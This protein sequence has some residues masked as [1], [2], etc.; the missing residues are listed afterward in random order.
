[1]GCIF[2]VEHEFVAFFVFELYDFEIYLVRVITRRMRTRTIPF[3]SLSAREFGKKTEN[4]KFQF[5]GE[6]C[7]S[8]VSANAG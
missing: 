2:V 4:S 8:K 5:Y 6:L 1:M 3:D 7:A